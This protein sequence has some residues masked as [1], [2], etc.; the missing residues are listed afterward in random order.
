[1][2]GFSYVEMEVKRR[3]YECTR[4][5]KTAAQARVRPPRAHW[6]F[7]LRYRAGRLGLAPSV[8]LHWSN[9]NEVDR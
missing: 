2:D 9:G 6:W 1:M 7:R 3:H 4:C 8:T 5:G